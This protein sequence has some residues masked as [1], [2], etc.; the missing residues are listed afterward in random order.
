MSGTRNR[1]GSC[2]DIVSTPLSVRWTERPV[3]HHEVQ[4]VLE[5]PHLLLARGQL[6]V[7]EA[8]ELD[9]LHQLLHAR[10]V[11]ELQQLLVL[12]HSELR[13]VEQYGAVVRGLLVREQR[14]ALGDQVVRDRGLFPDQLHH[15]A[16]ELGVLLVRL[17]AN[18]A[19]MMSGVLASSMRIESTSR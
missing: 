17:G 12:R 4:V 8:V 10:L 6:P 2:G 1:V 16:V 19:E 5:L 7:G 18:G 11:Q 14:F 9:P 13:L 15:L 3:V